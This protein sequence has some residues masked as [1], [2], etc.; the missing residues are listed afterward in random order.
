MRKFFALIAL[1][2]RAMARFLSYIV[3]GLRWSP[4]PWLAFIGAKIS[5]GS[6]ALLAWT[7]QNKK[8]VMLAS[9]ALGVTGLIAAGGYVW[10]LSIPKP[11]ELSVSGTS[12]AVTSM[13]D[14]PTFDSIQI[15]FSGSAAKLVQAGKA[16][17]KGISIDPG[18]EGE[19]R[20]VGDSQITFRPKVDWAI[21]QKYVVSFDKSMFPKHV[22]LEDYEYTFSTVAFK[23]NI[24]QSEFYQD[25]RDPKLKK[26]VATVR[27][28]YPVDPKA[29][30]KRIS[31]RIK[32]QKKGFFGVG[33]ES[34]PFKVSYDKYK[35]KAFI[36]SNPITIP[37]KDSFMELSIASGIVAARGGNSTESKLRRRIRIP[38]V[39][40]F[41]RISNTQLTLVRNA[42]YEP[43]QVLVVQTTAGVHEKE[44][45]K[46]LK[47]YVLP[48]DYP[49]LG[50]VKPK[51]RYRWGDVREIGPEVLQQATELPLTALPTEREYA[52]LHSFKYKAPPGKYLYIKL[53]KG[54]ESYGS[55]RLAKVFDSIRRVPQFPRELKI[56][57]DGAILSLSGSKKLSIL[58]RDVGALR[59]R[60]GRIMP[61]QI[62][63]LISQT[64]GSEFKNPGFYSASSFNLDNISEFFH[65]IKTLQHLPH[66]KTQYSAFDF[67][68]Y[69]TTSGGV[70][71][72]LFYLRVEG[73]DER[74]KRPMG[75]SD[76]RLVLI[77]DLGM[78]VKDS[79]D[80]SHDVFVQSIRSGRPVAGAR[81]EI[82]G[83]NGL[84]VMGSTT[85][86]NGHVSFPS[87][88]GLRRE[89]APTVYLVRKGPDL[90]FLPYKRDDRQLNFSRFDTG[91]EV[92]RYAGE[93]LNAYLF[94]D[95]GLYRPGD[96][97]H[98]GMII[99]PR[100][101]RTDLAGVPLETIITDA[102]GLT[103]QKKKIRLSAAGFEE[104]TY[105]TSETSP[106][107]EYQVRVYVIKDRKRRSLLGSTTVRVEEFLPDRLKIATSF[108][109]AQTRGWVSPDKLNGMVSLQNLF[110]TAAINRRVAAQLTLSPAYPVF[111]PFKDYRFYDPLRAKKS[112][113]ERLKDQK[114]DD[115]GET[116]FD[117]DLGR[118]DKATYRL[119]FLSQGFEAAGGRGVT[120]ESSILVSPLKYL[121]GYKADGSLRYIKRHGERNVK[122][123]AI[124]S[125]LKQH[126]VDGLK[127]H[128][129][130]QRYVSVLTRQSSG[131]Y[132]YQSVLKETTISKKPLTIAA[133]GLT[134]KLPTNKPGDY[135]LLIRDSEDTELNRIAF[136]IVGQANLAQSL[137]KNTELQ[138]KLNKSDYSP[139]EDIELQI[140]APYV[141][142][143]LITI[144]RDRVYTYK[145]FTTTT[146][147][148]VQ[149]IRIPPGMEGNGYIN[150]SFVRSIDSKEIYSSPL[151]YGVVPFSISRKK[152]IIPIELKVPELARPGEIY[153]IQ[154][155][156]AQPSRIV[157]IVVDEGILQVAKHKKPA[158]LSHFFKKKALEVTTSQILDL[159]LPEY[160]LVRAL[161]APGG[162]YGETALGKNLNP[163]KRKR[164]KPV[165]FWSGIID[166]GPQQRELKFTIPDH[167]NGTLRVVAVAVSTKAVGVVSTKSLVRGHF[168]ISPNV[169]T[170]VAPGDEFEV[171]AGIAN[172]V[173]KSGKTPVVNVTLQTS[174]HLK[175]IGKTIRTMTIA[176]G[177]ESVVRYKLVATNKLGSGNLTFRT[178]M[179][180]Y[181]SKYSIDLSVRPQTP[182]VTTTISG[183]FKP[184]SKS[185][186][187]IDRRMYPHYRKL[188]ASASPL[189]LGI[190]HGLIQYLTAYPHGCTEQLVSKAI[191][192]LVLRNRPEFGYSP[193]KVEANLNRT[194]RVLRQR[195]NA[196]GAFGFWAANSH[197]S[198]FQVVYA[199]HFLTEAKDKGYPVPRD[200]LRRG[201]SYLRGLMKDPG[202]SLYQAR[203]R[204]YALY[205]LTRN[206]V[207][208]T[209]YVNTLREHMDTEYK[210]TWKKDLAGIY[211]AATYKMLKLESQ[212]SRLIG[213]IKL[214]EPQK[215]NYNH[216]YDGL[217]RDAQ[218]LY[219]L[220]RHFPLRLK[221]LPPE[222]ILHI[223]IPVTKGNYNT[224]SSAYTIM[225]LDAFADVVDRPAQ[226]KLAITEILTQGKTRPLVLPRGLFPKVDFTDKAKF[227]QISAEGGFHT[228]Y[229]V[230]QSGFDLQLPQKVMKKKLEVFREFRDANGDVITKTKLGEEIK[231]HLKIR[232]IDKGTY[233]NVA[234]VD[235][236]PGGFEVVISPTARS[237]DTTSFADSGMSSWKPDY[238]DIRED[239]VVLYGTVGPDVKE[240]VYRIK[241]TNKGK[242]A[243]PPIFAE[244]MYDRAAQAR[245]LGAKIVVEGH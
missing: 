164:D 43:E 140:K 87:L 231:V 218:Y 88:K 141:G 54:I 53:N 94:S 124:N 183:S 220:A 172:N 100:N 102:R 120:S 7:R 49:A 24:L 114:T 101:W 81:V 9:V 125:K 153:R 193:K 212:A 245:A 116:A 213:D 192:A 62:N 61:G 177:K 130:E 223:V 31:M 96:T 136:S 48:R 160:E 242:Y 149:H 25:P 75:V 41:F 222:A 129:L 16:I 150:V 182:Y 19:W 167:F 181:Q 190:G 219:I 204:A 235:L 22:L 92:T 46:N 70:N 82:L 73:W 147:S 106:T 128:L 214:G 67:G 90:S 84:A 239:R 135:V 188:T 47:V 119:T 133:Q 10:Y 234:I 232:S 56:M 166:A 5:V 33:K 168:V 55:F 216:Y 39:F 38:G 162:G 121:I 17:K 79:A 83:K 109:K 113:S 59:Y 91:G 66:G 85:D 208:T 112:F 115:K 233:S 63:H 210:G 143:G 199:L 189:P 142:S 197:V 195:Q 11:V 170:F 198:D 37:P 12:P 23:A 157:V 138:V 95:R 30:E 244:A 180:K 68:N 28:N 227:V 171:S 139:G 44:L 13:V 161:S 229:Q 126:K 78:L 118:F 209:N 1:M 178:T 72:G 50:D 146:T 156:S 110:G 26:I 225:A 14:N 165:A 35:G 103:V 205:I 169:P 194:L 36:H 159:I 71:R 97:F 111:R 202:D 98:I 105:K 51:K 58:S 123:I 145:W 65:N 29:F 77:T 20:W 89:K 201:L 148:S 241:A 122:L 151:S 42:R 18:I 217:V 45:Q 173:E 6:C 93:K 4:P 184:G 179:G 108:S 117:L 21:G 8:T 207:V 152:R 132:K 86:V 163:F 154:Y 230:V 32:G 40:N 176:E 131:T 196:R 107:G 158:P 240:F 144:E 174:K 191:P 203:V 228:Y 226:S 211:M 236:L 104:V 185:K 127:A 243:V 15:N 200:M 64:S 69:L 221:K 34:F 3:G 80:G 57:H 238:V 52:K 74:R 237:G 137:E 2:F 175:I 155:K 134:Y 27:F 99:K 224:I 76:G 60:I 206:G 186:V 187:L 215:A